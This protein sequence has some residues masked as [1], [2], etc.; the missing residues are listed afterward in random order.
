MIHISLTRLRCFGVALLIGLCACVIQAEDNPSDRRASAQEARRL[1]VDSLKSHSCQIVT[2]EKLR[3]NVGE[4]THA[5]PDSLASLSIDI[6]SLAM[7]LDREDPYSVL[8][9]YLY[10]WKCNDLQRMNSLLINTMRRASLSEFDVIGNLSVRRV[11]RNLESSE[12][13]MCFRVVMDIDVINQGSLTSG[14]HIWDCYV[15]H[16]VEEKWLVSGCG[17]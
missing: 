17:F 2:P 9:S 6:D 13:V 16:D 5:L 1:H 15:F 11:I 12:D 3:S 14:R 8:C 7:Q 4:N 10:A